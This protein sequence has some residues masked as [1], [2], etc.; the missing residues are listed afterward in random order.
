MYAP[1]PPPLREPSV[2]P[3][4]RVVVLTGVA[5]AG[6]T[7]VGRALAARLGWAFADA[8]DYHSAAANAR[9]ARGQGLTDADRAPWLDR[10]AALVGDRVRGGPPTVLAC[11]ALK[12]AYRDRLAGPGVA[13]AWLDVP[14]DVLAERLRRREGHVAGPD[15]LPSQ[16]A[17]LEPP[18]GALRLD[19]TRPVG[20]LAET[21]A[22]WA[23]GAPAASGRG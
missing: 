4:P 22:R 19:G 1:P 21:A 5:G 10:L 6:K 16:L 15:L 18:A 8:D 14:P 3:P 11:S 7:T 23:G 13:F 2:T 12:A 9:M 17:T 20:A